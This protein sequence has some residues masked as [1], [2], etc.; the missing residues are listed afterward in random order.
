MILQQLII[1]LKTNKIKVWVDDGNLKFSAPKGAMTSELKSRLVANKSD[2]IA[3]LQARQPSVQVSKDDQLQVIKSTPEKL[4]FAQQ[5]L[6]FMSDT[7]GSSRAYNMPAVYRISG[8]LDVAKLQQALN[9]VI[10]VHPVLRTGFVKSMGVY[11]A[12]LQSVNEWPFKTVELHHSDD[13]AVNVLEAIDHEF[14]LAQAPLAAATLIHQGDNNYRLVLNLHH[15]V[16]DGWSHQLLWKHIWQVYQGTD[17]SVMAEDETYNYGHFV[18]WQ[19]EWLSSEDY[20]VQKQFWGHYLEGAPQLIDLSLDNPRPSEPDYTGEVLE[21]DL[22]ADMIPRLEKVALEQNSS[23]YMVTLAALFFVMHKY[24]GQDDICIGTPVANRRMKAWDSVM[25]LFANV[26]TLRQHLNVQSNLTDLMT[27]VRDNVLSVFEYQDFPFERVVEHLQPERSLSYSPLFQIMFIFEQEGEQ[28]Q[29]PGLSFVQDVEDMGISKF[30][31]TLT[32]KRDGDNIKAGFEYNNAIFERDSIKGLSRHYLHVLGEMLDAADQPLKNLCLLNQKEQ[33]ACLKV[34]NG[35]AVEFDRNLLVHQLVSNQSEKTPQQLALFDGTTRLSY[36]ELETLSSNIAANLQQQGVGV[37]DRVGIYFERSSHMV[38]AMI[39]AMRC[40]AAYVP[41]DLHFPLSRQQMIVQDGQLSALLTDSAHQSGAIDLGG[42][43]LGEKVLCVDSLP[44]CQWRGDA[45]V[46]NGDSLAYVIFTSGSTGRPKGVKVT[47]TNVHNLFAGLDDSLGDTIEAVDGIPTFRA[48]T[49]ISFDISVL[50][51]F[52]TLSRGFQVV[53]EQ[54]HFSALAEQSAHSR[55]A[56]PMHAKASELDFSFFYF[57]SDEDDSTDKYFLLR[58]GAKFADKNGFSAVWTPER[59]FHAFGGHFPNPSVAGAMVAAITDNIQ[60]RSGSVVL[61]LHNP[62]RVAEEWSMVDNM[63]NGRVGLSIASGWHFNDFVLAP[64]NFE[65]RH[66]IMAESMD[67]LKSLWRGDSIK[68]I[69]GKGNETDIRV[70]PSTIRK[71]LPMWV[72]AAANPETFRLAGAGGNN[73]LTH[74][75]GQSI[76]ELKGKIDIYRKARADA[77][78]DPATGNVTLML[79]TY[80]HDDYDTA[81]SRVEVAFKN[82]LRTSINLLLPVAKDNGL[83]AKGDL[84]AVV[85][86]GFNRYAK[87][88]ALFGTPESCTELVSQ[89]A[90]I[91][92][93]EIGCLIDFGVEQDYVVESFEQM[94]LLKDR[95]Q[96]KLDS[97]KNV[98]GDV[99]LVDELQ[100]THLQCTPSYAQLMLESATMRDSLRPLKG[101]LV[102]GEALTQELAG[103]LNKLVDGRLFN[104]YGPTETTVWSAV[105]EVIGNDA[106]IGEPIANTQIYILDEHHNPLP[107]GVKGEMYIGG[108]GVSAGYWQR[109]DLTIEAFMADPFVEDSA[110]R[111]YRTG[112]IVSRRA[113]GRIHYIGR[114]DNQVKVRGFRVE[115]DEI[116]NVLAQLP[117]ITQAAAI[118]HEGEGKNAMIFAYVVLDPAVATSE[119]ADDTSNLTAAL[120][121][122]LPEYMVPSH[123]FVLQSM[124]YTPNGKLDNKALPKKIE[125]NTAKLV[126]PANDTETHIATIW[127]ELLKLD[128]IGTRD[129]FFELGGHSLLLGAMQQ[130]LQAQ[131]NIEIEIIDLFKYPTINSLGKRIVEELGADNT[132]GVTPV[133]NPNKTGGRERRQDNR[134]ALNQVRNQMRQRNRRGR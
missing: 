102:G 75:L 77:G 14:D 126:P 6:L 50:E 74:L 25:G 92:V 124:P 117:Q 123:I 32:L 121:A 53:I 56:K 132:S 58:E 106:G 114:A 55:D 103:D 76:D 100:A 60:I 51:L 2:L 61:P 16:S 23:L 29:V 83:D 9:Q 62:I 79:H 112:D 35:K 49:S 82:Y 28:L 89:V 37:G 67:T 84:D 7:F 109:D 5:R 40:G 26:V 91:D 99:A 47:H 125:R 22:P 13:M 86:V 96:K 34:A 11:Q 105:G 66:K 122:A 59:H 21:F 73:V 97:N 81:M 116:R 94:K 127:R 98:D 17:V 72:T 43:A 133:D 107:P 78:F 88:S 128:A 65:N 113:D 87:T 134:N 19:Q 44:E 64:D 111:M 69:D 63:S 41:V 4:S 80:I 95:V 10:G 108:E 129:S 110:A 45:P 48:L 71:E 42:E 118:V 12:Q 68:A 33:A 104:M 101:L 1:D 46:Q 24:T 70:Y 119:Q 130:K 38:A 39:G 57:A 3:M 120:K 115:L 131:F 15:V 30:D 31:F 20:E 54:D 52:W 8:N 93:D 85:D 36:L 18:A 27:Q 90:A